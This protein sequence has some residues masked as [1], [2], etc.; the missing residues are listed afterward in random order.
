MSLPYERAIT[1]VSGVLSELITDKDLRAKLEF[2]MAKALLTTTTTPKVDAT[3]KLLMALRDLAIPLFRPVGS[4]ALAAFGAYCVTNGIEL[5]EYISVML[6]GAP[7]GW[8][9]SRHKEKTTA[10][11]KRGANVTDEDF[12]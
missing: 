8:G 5:P 4:V 6:F 11:P 3:V 10:K 7:L 2:E 9:M 1:S 12:E